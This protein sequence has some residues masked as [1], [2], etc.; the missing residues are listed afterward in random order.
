MCVQYSTLL[1]ADWLLS[2]HAMVHHGKDMERERGIG[3]GRR[4]DR[5]KE[6]NAYQ[7]R[8]SLF[9]PF[10]SLRDIRV[11]IGFGSGIENTVG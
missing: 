10:K 5:T 2:H 7:I 1:R 9:L 4:R 8:K 11:R 6:R 3:G